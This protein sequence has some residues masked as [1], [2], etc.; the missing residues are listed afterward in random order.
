LPLKIIRESYSEV[1]GKGLVLLSS[2]PVI[3]KGL[4]QNI[5]VIVEEAALLS[6]AHALIEKP[7]R[8]L[9]LEGLALAQEEFQASIQEF[10]T[11]FGV[12]CVLE[13][14]ARDEPGIEIRASRSESEQSQLADIVKDCFATDF[15]VQISPAKSYTSDNHSMQVQVISILLGSYESRLRRDLLVSRI[16]DAVNVLNAALGHLETD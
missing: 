4:D 13:I 1:I 5:L 14:L 3:S 15:D 2:P 10:F 16:A 11:D 7:K 12:R 8:R 9:D 6:K